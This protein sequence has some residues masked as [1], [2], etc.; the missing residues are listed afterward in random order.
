[1]KFCEFLNICRFNKAC[2]L[3]SKRCDLTITQA[4]L[5]SGFGSIRS[6]NRVFKAIYGQTPHQYR[7]GLSELR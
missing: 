3:L 2:E 5:E 7:K 4:A 1:M 6:F